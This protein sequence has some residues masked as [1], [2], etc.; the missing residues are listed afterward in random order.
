[1]KVGRCCFCHRC[2]ILALRRGLLLRRPLVHPS[3][4]RMRRN[5]LYCRP[6][7]LLRRGRSM[8]TPKLTT[9]KTIEIGDTEQRSAL[10]LA[11]TLPFRLSP[12]RHPSLLPGTHH[13]SSS[14]VYR[15]NFYTSFFR[16]G[17]RT[18]HGC[19]HRST[20]VRRP[21]TTISLLSHPV[22]HCHH[23]EATFP[24]LP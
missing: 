13:T 15:K 7:L 12:T 16:Y 10:S 3:W 2:P 17:Y 8:Q 11:T 21:V 22:A 5:R 20:S 9:N 1:M 24:E 6:T 23:A 19:S 14:R 18:Y 4:W